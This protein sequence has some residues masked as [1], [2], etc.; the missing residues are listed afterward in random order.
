M[1]APAATVYVDLPILQA[2]LAG[3]SAGQGFI[4]AAGEAL[5]PGHPVVRFVAAEA[6]AGR[7][8]LHNA[9][10][11]LNDR[12]RR[13]VVKRDPA[14]QCPAGQ[15]AAAIRADPGLARLL[16]VLGEVRGPCPSDARLA[17][18]ARL[19]DR[20]AAQYRLRRLIDLGLVSKR[21]D[22]RLGRIVKVL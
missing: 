3:A 18:L 15:V 5:D 20:H 6:Q 17:E 9:G 16:K 1:P 4:Y 13:K 7:A 11:D 21:N 2:S 22:A 10:R 19:P 8:S 14:D 12:L